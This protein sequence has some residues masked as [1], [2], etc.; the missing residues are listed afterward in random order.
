MG[1]HPCL[2]RILT[3]T[4]SDGHHS[5]RWDRSQHCQSSDNRSVR[6]QR[7]ERERCIRGPEGHV[8]YPV[9]GHRPIGTS[10]ASGVS[11]APFGVAGSRLS[12]YA[13]ACARS[14][15]DGSALYSAVPGRAGS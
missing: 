15:P 8:E 7:A 12:Q 1:F 11:R 9:V 13:L 4:M 3:V 6:I 10:A 5:A 14:L 2:D